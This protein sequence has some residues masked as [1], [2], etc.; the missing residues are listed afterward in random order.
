[1]SEGSQE[2]KS[3]GFGN[4]LKG[5]GSVFYE[6]DP[7]KPVKKSTAPVESQSKPTG[8]NGTMGTPV[9]ITPQVFIPTTIPGADPQAIAEVKGNIFSNQTNK[10]PLTP[11]E[12]FQ[13]ELTKLEAVL[14]DPF[15]RMKVAMATSALKLEDV[16]AGIS[17][18]LG[19]VAE[20]KKKVEV[21]AA[22][23]LEGQVGSRQKELDGINGQ[24]QVVKQQIVLLQEQIATQQ[25]KLKELSENKSVIEQD[26]AVQKQKIESAKSRL[27]LAMDAVVSELET[28]RNNLNLYGKGV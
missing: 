6:A 25:G 15:Q 26:M 18:H 2:K 14:P 24:E 8:A 13:Q 10:L 7:P 9:T 11:Y 21:S 17:V 22:M 23:A 27:Y 28:E 16:V 12:R 19:R 5:L 1:M 4:V 3:G 20:Q